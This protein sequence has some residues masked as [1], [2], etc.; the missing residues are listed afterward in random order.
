MPELIGEFKTLIELL[1]W[2][3]RT[4]RNQRGKGAQFV[5]PIRGGRTILMKL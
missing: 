4:Y 3:D 2:F 5:I 1:E